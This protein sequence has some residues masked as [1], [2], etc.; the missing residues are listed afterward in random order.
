MTVLTIKVFHQFN[1]LNG[2]EVN[3]IE[4]SPFMRK[5]Q[6]EN[7]IKLLQKYDIWMKFEYDES[8]RSKMEKFTCENEGYF[9]TLKWFPMYEHYIFENF[10]DIAFRE[11][12]PTGGGNMSKFILI[13]NS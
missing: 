6:Q 8:K 5:L 9:L 3:F 2:I 7:I 10:G 1:L 12:K 13:I 4:T 11:F